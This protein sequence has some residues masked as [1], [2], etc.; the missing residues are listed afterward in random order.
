MLLW[1]GEEKDLRLRWRGAGGG[2]GRAGA[3]GMGAAGAARRGALE[4]CAGAVR[5]ADAGAFICAA[6][7]EPGARARAL[8]ARAFAGEAARAALGGR[9]PTLA[10]MRLQWWRDAVGRAARGDAPDQPVARA[11]GELYAEA[12]AAGRRAPNK[13]WLLRVLQARE[14]EVRGEGTWASLEALERHAEATEGSL[15]L[16]TLEASGIVDRNCDHAASHLGTA[17]GLCRNLRGTA[18]QL[19]AQRLCL[20]AD[21]CEK[22]GV[23]TEALYRGDLRDG[24]LEIVWE[25]ASQAKL[26]LDEARRFSADMPAAARPLFLPAVPAELYLDVLER[27]NFN[28]FATA[29]LADDRGVSGLT[30]GGHVA[31]HR[32]RGSY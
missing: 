8:A 9:Q 28:P 21:L 29:L 6:V 3:A 15:L 24:F 13:G 19:Q 25:V 30:M 31:W 1:G 10:L 23:E 26:H 22:H 20:P 7:L 17:L 5:G 27:H 4:Y 14:G 11:I 18:E 2:G 32:L 12:A 16:F